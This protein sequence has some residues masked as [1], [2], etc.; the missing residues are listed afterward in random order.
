MVI[1]IL[2]SIFINN[3]IIGS[4]KFLV[5]D[6]NISLN[7]LK[8]S[9]LDVFLNSEFSRYDFDFQLISK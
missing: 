5:H 4:S 7:T 1:F 6:K 9:E 3:F 8:I 2:V